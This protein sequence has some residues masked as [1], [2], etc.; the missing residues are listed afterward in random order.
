VQAGIRDNARVERKDK[1]TVA[2]VDMHGNP[3]SMVGWLLIGAGAI[4]MFVGISLLLARRLPF[5]G[6]LPGDIHYRGENFEFH[7]PLV[8]CLIISAVITLV[9]WVIAKLR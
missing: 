8:T 6:N 5:I 9:L 2:Q 3:V 7:F 4:L 1:G